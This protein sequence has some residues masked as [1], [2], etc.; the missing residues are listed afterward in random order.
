MADPVFK[1][2]Q[3]VFSRT[4]PAAVIVE[5]V[6]PSQISGFLQ[7]SKE[8]TNSNYDL[9]DK[10]CGEPEFAAYSALQLGAPV[11]TGEPAGR[12][13]LS[14]FEAHGYSIQDVFA[15]YVMI[16]IAFQSRNLPIFEDALPKF[17]DRIVANENYTYGTSVRFT[18]ANFSAWYA[19]HMQNPQNYL[20]LRVDDTSPAAPGE[21]PKTELHA[22][23]RVFGQVRDENVL[24]TVRSVLR[25]YNRVLVVY[26]ASHVNFEWNGLVQL[27][28]VPVQTKP[29]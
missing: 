10:D 26:G 14:L 15:Y 28:G 11:F 2:I 9:P 18:A 17:V 3:Q 13:L 29:F 4:P 23:S 1:T 7:F 8:C 5:G 16:N 21:T 27:L 24:R 22:L 25:K 6:D 20:E 19:K 12:A